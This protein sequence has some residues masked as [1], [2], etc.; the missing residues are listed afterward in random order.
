LAFDV[1]GPSGDAMLDDS[2][3]DNL[4]YF[5]EGELAPTV[6]YLAY[7]IYSRRYQLQAT[8][9]IPTWVV[10]HWTNLCERILV[11]GHEVRITDIA[12]KFF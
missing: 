5:G 3:L 8:F 10:T 7:S 6:P 4:R 12:T 2:L 9:F 11:A 1:D